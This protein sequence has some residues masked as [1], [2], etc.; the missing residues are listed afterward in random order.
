MKE[1]ILEI[2]NPSELHIHDHQLE[3]QQEN[4]EV[5]VSID[6][7]SLIVTQG[8]DIR[9]STMDISIL[10]ENN[11]LLLTV[12]KNYL[13]SSM[14]LTY[15]ANS[16]QSITMVKQLE[17]SKRKIN[18]LWNTIIQAKI[19]NQSKVLSLLGKEGS[20]EIYEYI[21]KINRGDKD[22]VEA[23]A[24]NKY[25]QYYYPGLNR[26]KEF[27]INSCLNYG[28]SIIRSSLARTLAIHG[29]L[30]SKGLHH[31]SSLNAFNLVDDLIEP[32]RAFVDYNAI[33]VVS[34]NTNLTKEQ[35]KRLLET[36]FMECRINGQITTL[37]IAMDMYV[38]S[39]KDYVYGRTEELIFPEVIPLKIRGKIEE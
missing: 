18:Y 29:F 3:I 38:N 22:N 32:F 6:E 15:N 35:R 21:H 24:A 33:Q 23:I 1:R 13:P 37:N 17:L 12:G 31:H 30:L 11:V 2:T 10:A 25:F 5:T 4:K 7:L 9:L 26:R 8:A 36:V 27:P 14:T 39:F 34:N 28:Y 19:K 16:R 20:E